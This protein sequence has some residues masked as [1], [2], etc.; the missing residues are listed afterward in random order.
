M[1]VKS[2]FIICVPMLIL[3][4][5]RCGVMAPASKEITIMSYNLM[6]LFDPVDQ[7]GEYDGW[8]VARGQWDEKGYRTRIANT[9]SAV[10]SAIPG[11]PDVLVVIEAENKRVLSDLAD[12]LGGYAVILSSPEEQALLSCGILSRFPLR[13]AKAHLATPPSDAGDSIPR[14]ML[15]AELDVEGKCL[16]VLA[17]HWKS[18][19]GGAKETEKARR[20]AADLVR[21]IMIERI[22]EDPSAG[23]LLAGD[24]NE[25]PEEYD[26]VDRKYLTALMPVSTAS[27]PGL[28]ISADPQEA[29]LQNGKLVL[30][31][32][33]EQSEGYSYKFSGKEERIDNILLS[34]GL[35]K[36]DAFRF[37]SFSALPPAFLVD[38]TG[39]P[40]KWNSKSNTGYSDH[41]PIC[42][43]LAMQKKELSITP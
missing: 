16:I 41:L 43:K 9:A 32:P 38:E 40:I 19:L 30:F 4:L 10:L 26:L 8:S 27:G 12:R 39:Q 18:K 2:V 14:Y 25:N 24:L 6:T 13:Q 31:S 33:W 3:A 42:L 35:I 28:Y 17:A 20:F 7:G 29:C 36:G 15:E 1:R 21:R 5:T 22:A 34:P 23:I 11:G 37:I